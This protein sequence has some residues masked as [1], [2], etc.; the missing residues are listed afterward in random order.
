MSHFVLFSYIAD[1]PEAKDMQSL[2]SGVSTFPSCHRCLLKKE[3]FSSG[4]FESAWALKAAIHIVERLDNAGW[5][6][7]LIQ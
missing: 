5:K 4:I 3:R 7:E 6:D 1:I 2:N